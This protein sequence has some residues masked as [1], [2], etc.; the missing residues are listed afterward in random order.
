MGLLPAALLAGCGGGEKTFE[1]DG[2]SFTYPGDW[3]Q[4]KGSGAAAEAGNLVSSTAFAPSEG[5][6]GLTVSVY[7]LQLAVTPS[8]I[9]AIAPEAAA[10]TEQI[11]RQAGGRV[12]TG[13][14]RVTVA[15]HPGFAVKGT[16]LTPEG[17]RVQSQVTMLFDGKTEYFLNCQFTPEQAEDMIAGC[18]KALDSLEIG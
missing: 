17:V 16:A 13:P 6:S 12:T 1:G 15:G 2:Y 5:A 4:R 18:S 14:R 10:V 3:E 9:D 8:N 11:F 7:H